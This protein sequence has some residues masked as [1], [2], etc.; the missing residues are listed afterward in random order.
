[1]DDHLITIEVKTMICKTKGIKATSRRG[2]HVHMHMT[3]RWFNCAVSARVIA[4][5]SGGDLWGE[6][7]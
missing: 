7:R 4:T 3:K 6:A 5:I 1:M 2:S